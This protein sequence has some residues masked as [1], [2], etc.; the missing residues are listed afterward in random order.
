MVLLEL[1]QLS[2]RTSDNGKNL[3]D[4]GVATTPSSS[5]RQSQT[6]FLVPPSLVER[7]MTTFQAMSAGSIQSGLI[8]GGAGNDTIT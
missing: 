2:S 4:G 6:P 8:R 1:T 3:N 5:S 7:V